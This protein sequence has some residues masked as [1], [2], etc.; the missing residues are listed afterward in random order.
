VTP[1]LCIIYGPAIAVVVS[2]AKRVPVVARHPKWIAAALSLLLASSQAWLSFGIGNSQA[3]GYD[4]LAVLLVCV[5]EQLSGA[6][7][8]YEALIKPAARPKG[9]L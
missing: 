2:L 5:A 8:T 4:A 6:V 7:L 9:D 3:K 1:D